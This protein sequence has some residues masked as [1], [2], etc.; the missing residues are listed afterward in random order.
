LA[1]KRGRGRP[2]KDEAEGQ[3]AAREAAA[4]AAAQALEA[5]AAAAAATA[6]GDTTKKQKTPLSKKAAAAAAE[7]SAVAALVL[8]EYEELNEREEEGAPKLREWFPIPEYLGAYY[9]WFAAIKEEKQEEK[10][11][12]Q[13]GKK[14]ADKKAEEPPPPPPPQSGRHTVWRRAGFLL[15][16]R[17]PASMSDVANVADARALAVPG[18]SLEAFIEGGWWAAVGAGAEGQQA[19]AAAAAG[20]SSAAARPDSSNNVAVTVWDQPSKVTRVMAPQH[21]RRMLV[22][23]PSARGAVWKAGSVDP[24]LERWRQ[25]QAAAAAAAAKSPARK[26]KK[27]ADQAPG[28]QGEEHEGGSGGALTTTTSSDDDDDGNDNGGDRTPARG[29]RN[30]GSASGTPERAFSDDDAEE[31]AYDRRPYAVPEGTDTAAIFEALDP[32]LSALLRGRSRAARAAAPR[33]VLARWLALREEEVPDP[34]RRLRYSKGRHLRGQDARRYARAVAELVDAFGSA[35]GGQEEAAAASSGPGLGRRRRPAAVL[36]PPAPTPFSS[37]PA[38]PRDVAAVPDPDAIAAAPAVDLRELCRVAKSLIRREAIQSYDRYMRVRR[39][40]G[41]GGGG[42]GEDEGAGGGGGRGGGTLVPV[43]MGLGGRAVPPPPGTGSRSWQGPAGLQG[44]LLR[45]ARRAA[46][47]EA[48]RKRHGEEEEEGGG[49][50]AEEEAAATTTTAP[51]DLAD[52]ADALPRARGPLDTWQGKYMRVFSSFAA[53]D[54]PT[55]PL[56]RV[57]FVAVSAR[58]AANARRPLRLAPSDEDAL[59]QARG[60]QPQPQQPVARRARLQRANA[61]AGASESSMDED[62]DEGDAE[63][64]AAAGGAAAALPAVPSALYDARRGFLEPI[65]VS[66]SPAI[67][68]S[69][70]GSGGGRGRHCHLAAGTRSGHVHV[71]RLALPAAAAAEAAADAA[72]PSSASAAPLSPRSFAYAGSVRAHAGYVTALA[73]A[74]VSGAVAGPV[75]EAC[76]SDGAVV[77]ATGAS[78]GEVRLWLLQQESGNSAAASAALPSPPFACVGTA[79]PSDGRPVTALDATVAAVGG[80][81]GDE[82]EE[83]ETRPPRLKLLVAAAKTL[84]TVA[85]WSSGAF[86][87]GRAPQQQQQQ[88]PVASLVAVACSTGG[89]VSVRARA[90]GLGSATGAVIDPHERLL[91]T[92]GADGLVRCWHILG[93][94]ASKPSEPEAAGAG[95][96]PLPVTPSPHPP[97]RYN[98]RS[99]GAHVPTS[100]REAQVQRCPVVGL[101]SPPLSRLAVAALRDVSSG[102]STATAD[103]TG[104]GRM[105]FSRIAFA[106]VHLLTPFG[107]EGVGGGVSSSSSP[108][109]RAL[110]ARDVARRAP[111]LTACVGGGGGALPA[112]FWDVGAA[113]SRAGWARLRGRGQQQQE[114]DDPQQQQPQMMTGEERRAAAAA[115]RAVAE[116]RAVGTL[117]LACAEALER[118]FARVRARF[119]PT[120]ANSDALYASCTSSDW[121]GLQLGSALRRSALALMS[122]RPLA[123]GGLPPGAAEAVAKDPA[124][125]AARAALAKGLGEAEMELVQRQ[126]RGLLDSS[127]GLPERFAATAANAPQQQQPPPLTSPATEALCDRD[128]RA[129]S[130]LLAAD[131]VALAARH[132]GLRAHAL[133]PR[134]ARLYAAARLAPPMP[135]LAAAPPGRERNPLLPPL[136]MEPPKEDEAMDVDGGAGEPPLPRVGMSGGAVQAASTAAVAC[137]AYAIK[138]EGEGEG[139][140]EEE[141]GGQAPPP[142]P[143][144]VVL[145]M[146]RCAASLRV[147]PADAPCAR[148][149]VC[150]RHYAVYDATTPPP[151]CVVCGLR[152]AA[153]PTAAA[154]ACAG[155][156]AAQTLEAP[157]ARVLPSAVFLPTLGA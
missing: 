73:F 4:L 63:D 40:G 88:Q 51:L 75:A 129:A 139:G 9:P 140:E 16:P 23:D 99:R 125:R 74:A 80:D 17:A 102:A 124:A 156:G 89:S 127:G 29:R 34:T 90:H 72:T 149:V 107:E 98:A 123:G 144:P 28:G 117:A 85:L 116:A 31:A 35:I 135:P 15:R 14:A 41:G 95:G 32:S 145:P 25:K 141:D 78:G 118:P 108:L 18:A 83:E 61:A 103:A 94:A 37:G 104:S 70:S 152:P 84:G 142:P 115:R 105:S 77:L 59:A 65:C 21:V 93:L 67:L 91:H 62:G 79:V 100:F 136:L 71:W 147:L 26:R 60:V 45:A 86:S 3:A 5:A 157:A 119:P 10:E 50:A 120:A 19:A 82:Q 27:K 58:P 114:E 138:G 22:W 48:E 87:A 46:A 101:A 148:C 111:A 96:G 30:R 92:S 2:R 109:G 39:R 54:Q 113:V 131:W 57:G 11:Q 20:P 132:P 150:G 13:R 38:A 42:G 153:P 66:W 68:E 1:V 76:A 12:Q 154:G 110:D 126:V 49:G 44:A 128:P 64:A 36:L 6:T 133:L 24:L 52:A 106:T 43:D 130:A 155:G 56:L 53:E 55:D 121:R 112:A 33:L 47:V 69:S 151:T 134:A 143:A 122:R 146:P 8:V 81:N 7:A 137:G 97:A